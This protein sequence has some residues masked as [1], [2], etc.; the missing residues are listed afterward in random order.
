M[1]KEDVLA[2]LEKEYDR[3]HA[4]EL[5]LDFNVYWNEMGKRNIEAEH[6][7]CLYKISILEGKLRDPNMRTRK[8][9]L[10]FKKIFK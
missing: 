4:L 6:R 2:E 5:S 1:Y 10:P 8:R 7:E 9:S 3:L